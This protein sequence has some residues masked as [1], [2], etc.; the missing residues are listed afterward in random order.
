MTKSPP[1]VPPKPTRLSTINLKPSSPPPLPVRPSQKKPS[2]YSTSQMIKTKSKP[3]FVKKESHLC[4]MS[5]V[6]S[7]SEEDDEDEENDDMDDTDDEEEEE[8]L[9]IVPVVNKGKGNE[10][11]TNPIL[12]G[13]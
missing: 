6:Y 8:E 1:P 10:I 13:L 5:D 9:Y 12:K 4:N 3:E 2:S 7:D 11:G